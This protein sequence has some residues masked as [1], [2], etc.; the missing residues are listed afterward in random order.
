MSDVTGTCT[1]QNKSYYI[2]LTDF[3]GHRGNRERWKANARF[4]I[5]HFN[6]IKRPAA[7]GVRV[8]IGIV[9]FRIC[10]AQYFSG[11]IAIIFP[12]AWSISTSDSS[13]VLR[14]TRKVCRTPSP[15]IA[16]V[17]MTLTRP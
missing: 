14:L 12:L 1:L 3:K 7:D 16:L 4:S 13:L 17:S 6:R 10:S 15:K 5:N 2:S 9:C 11:F 8:L